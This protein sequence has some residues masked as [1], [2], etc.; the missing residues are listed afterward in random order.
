[1][2]SGYNTRMARPRKYGALPMDRDLKIPVTSE[3][4]ALITEATRNESEGMAAWARVVLLDAAKK[5]IAKSDGKRKT[6]L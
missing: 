2:F 5:K 1:M 6:P 4:R 3:Q